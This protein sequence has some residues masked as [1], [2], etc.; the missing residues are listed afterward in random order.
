MARLE[1]WSSA[2]GC[3]LPDP[4]LPP[5]L[6]H[7]L[8]E[9]FLARLARHPEAD[10]FALRG[11]M[12]VR[13]VL[14]GAGRRVRDVDLLCELPYD[15]SGLRR[16]LGEVLSDR[17]VDD[18]VGFD[19]AGRHL[20]GVWRGPVTPALCL[21]AMGAVGAAL[22]RISVDVVFGLPVWP[23]PEATTLGA[24]VRLRVCRPE[25][26]IGRKVQVVTASGPHRWRPKD[27]ADLE[28]L[29]QLDLDVGT[30][31]QAVEVAFEHG[32]GSFAEAAE[33]FGRA[34]W[35]SSAPAVARWSRA[36]HAAHADPA[37]AAAAVREA[38]APV[39]GRP[40]EP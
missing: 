7:R 8:L 37:A 24:G 33:V 3:P 27:L 23:P 10:A 34:S 28:R 11:G 4:F 14:P 35:W 15:P 1:A 39:F 19:P 32:E 12:M 29:L 6:R 18:G 17:T 31:G 2:E 16:L 36:G 5:A 30:L 13:H 38:L 20:C 22:G 25:V 40:G 9:G 21:R 26:V